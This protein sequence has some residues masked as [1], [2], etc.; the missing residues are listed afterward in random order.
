MNPLIVKKHWQRAAQWIEMYDHSQSFELFFRSQTAQ[1]KNMGSRDRKHVKQACYAALRLGKAYSYLSTYNKIV[2]YFRLFIQTPNLDFDSLWDAEANAPIEFDPKGRPLDWDA[3]LMNLFP[4]YS[5]LSQRFQNSHF[6]LSHTSQGFLFFRMIKPDK[7]EAIREPIQYTEVR[8]GIYSVPAQTQLNSFVEKGW[9]QVQDISSQEAC[10][11]M[12]FPDGAKVWDVCAGAGGKCIHLLSRYPNLLFYTSDIRPQILRNLKKRMVLYGLPQPPT[13]VLN[14]ALPQDVLHFNILNEKQKSI[15]ALYKNPI[16]NPYFDALLI[17][18]PC[19]GSGVWRR[20][21]EHLSR[22]NEHAVKEYIIKQ[23]NIVTHSLPFLKP[24]G[25]LY[26]ITCSVFK[27]EN[28]EQSL[29]FENTLGLQ[30]KSETYFD[31]VSI[32]GDI[33]FLSVWVK[34]D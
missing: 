31:S 8:P 18:V 19:T 10:M 9:V 33:L 14:M 24:G 17:D 20:N 3:Q 25:T 1:Y 13:A 6:L 7:K 5:L 2:L 29:Y 15:H 34:K 16:A 28:E 26:Y 11:N 32:G 12:S 23:R 30:K 27:A 4:A 22:F 21:P